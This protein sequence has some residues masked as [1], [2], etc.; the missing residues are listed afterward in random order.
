LD[1]IDLQVLEGELAE[2]VG[3]PVD[4][5]SL[6]AIKP[7]WAAY[8]LI[9]QLTVIGEA[10]NRLSPS[11]RISNAHIPWPQIIGMRHRLIHDYKGIDIGPSGI[12][13]N[14]GCLN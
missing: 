3:R 2:R 8:I 12:P 13:P 7:H 1:I 10:S 5:V 11:T 4:L 14:C 9:R 6:S